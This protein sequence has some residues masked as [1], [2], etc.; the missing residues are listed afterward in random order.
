M[1]TVLGENNLVQF[2]VE[3][4]VQLLVTVHVCGV[5][6]E[7]EACT[8]LSSVNSASRCSEMDHQLRSPF[9]NTFTQQGLH[10]E[11]QMPAAAVVWSGLAW[12]V[13]LI[14]ITDVFCQT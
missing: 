5:W 4:A 8:G 9:L 11:S 3:S 6:R 12:V 2:G 1:Q 7:L 14:C 13:L 10:A